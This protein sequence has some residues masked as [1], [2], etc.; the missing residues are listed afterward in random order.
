M[1][2]QEPVFDRIAEFYDHTRR[3]P[4]KNEIDAIIRQLGGSKTVLEIGVGTGRI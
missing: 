4:L 1:E 2:N 3:P